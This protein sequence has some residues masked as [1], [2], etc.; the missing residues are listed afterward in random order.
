MPKITKINFDENKERYYIYID[1]SY[2]TSIRE[3]TFK[4]MNLSIGELISCEELKE[5][6]SFFWKEQY[7]DTWK[8]EKNRLN[9]VKD[10]FNY[11]T[12]T[13]NVQIEGFGADS[14]EIIKEHPDEKGK[15]DICIYRS[16]TDLTPILY[17]EVTGTSFM[18]GTE[19][20]VRP[21]KLEYAKNHPDDNVWIILHYLKPKEKFV[22]IKPDLSK[23][24][25]YEKVNIRG[26][27]EYFVKFNDDF[28]EVVSLTEFSRIIKNMENS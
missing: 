25:T 19:Y 9:R 28:E 7:K 22:F 11:Y 8:E 16:Q 4:A 17:V 6:E 10:L 2:C 15:P 23:K 1:Y 12:P 26:A 20:W 3:R 5:K 21:D 24:Y 14:T 27:D 13:F 18:R